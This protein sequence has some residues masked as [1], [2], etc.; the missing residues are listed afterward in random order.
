[1][2]IE[3]KRKQLTFEQQVSDSAYNVMITASIYL[4]D[5]VLFAEKILQFVKDKQE[6]EPAQFLTA[7]K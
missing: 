2:N 4:Y 6:K 1:M 5:P 7:K 3:E